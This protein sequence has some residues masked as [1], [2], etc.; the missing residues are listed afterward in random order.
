MK[1]LK[2]LPPNISFGPVIPGLSQGGIPQGLAHL[3]E[4][5]WLIVS[6]HFDGH[7]P[8]ML[9]VL[10]AKSGKLVKSITLLEKDGAPHLGH[11]GG[12]TISR[13]HLWVA[14]GGAYKARPSFGIV[15]Q[16]G[17]A[18]VAVSSIYRIPLEAI[19]KAEEVS[20]VRMQP[21]FL[22]ESNGGAMAV[23]NDVLW[24]SEWMPDPGDEKSP[25]HVID[26]EGQNRC[27]WVCGYRLNG[28]DELVA[29]R[30]SLSRRVTP[31]FVLVTPHQVQGIAFLK[32]HVVLAMSK[33]VNTQS[34]LDIYRDPRSADAEPHRTLTTSTGAQV[35]AW[36]LD[37]R[38][39]HKSFNIV[40]M[41]QNIVVRD[42]GLALISESG[43][44][45]FKS[46]SPLDR[47]VFI[48]PK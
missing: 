10:D 23:D 17:P 11:A 36:F 40:P 42:D 38:Q 48:K 41:T 33:G 18:W 13:G 44:P 4:K 39:L 24:V 9:G 35:P 26:R 1:L 30:Q 27:A 16:V 14:G 20:S 37:S 43:A 7:R 2:D 29:S 22:S 45:K 15:Q 47:V 21:W 25:H 6:L 5:D 3:P 28:E 46:N 34:K 8:S 31:D 19:L 32:G 12:I